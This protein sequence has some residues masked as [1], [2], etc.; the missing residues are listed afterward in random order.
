MQKMY[1]LAAWKRWV[2][3]KNAE[4]AGV[5]SSRSMKLV[6]EDLLTM[7]CEE[8]NYALC[9]FLKDLKKPNGETYQPDT[10]YYLLLGIQQHLFESSRIDCIFMD[11]GFEKFTNSLDEVTK[12][13]LKSTPSPSLSSPCSMPVT[14]ITE[15]M[16]WECR[17]LGAHTPQVLLNTLFYFNVKVFKLKTVEDHLNMSF[18]QIVK[19]WRRTTIGREGSVSRTALLKYYPKKSSIEESKPAPNYEMHENRDDPLRCPVKLYE[20]YL[21]KWFLEMWT[22]QN[23]AQSFPEGEQYNKMPLNVNTAVTLI[24]QYAVQ[25]MEISRCL[26]SSTVVIESYR[27]LSAKYYERESASVDMDWVSQFVQFE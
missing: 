24:V 13:F 22:A 27:L 16:L 12:T 5:S 8:L 1:G 10:I 25:Y 26:Y 9:L 19:Q 20:F 6:P 21:S 3:G 7:N 17:Q 11:F 4:L 15:A 23:F 18:V 14:R 2:T